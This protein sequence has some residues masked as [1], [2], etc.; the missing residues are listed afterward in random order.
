MEISF[1]G[2]TEVEVHECVLQLRTLTMTKA[3]VSLV[4]YTLCEYNFTRIR[5]LRL[6]YTCQSLVG[7]SVKGNVYFHCDEKL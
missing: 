1:G 5:I 6:G 4:G 2:E 3:E 7:S